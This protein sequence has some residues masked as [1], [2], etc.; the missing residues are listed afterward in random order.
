MIQT[1]RL[2]LALLP[3]DVVREALEVQARTLKI[4]LQPGGHPTPKHK[5]HLTLMFLGDA[6]PPDV[7]LKMRHAMRRISVAPFEFTLDQAGSFSGTDAWWIGSRQSS[8]ELLAL[9]ESIRELID[10]FVVAKD[11]KRFSPHV[12]IFRGVGAKLPSTSLPPFRW[13]VSEVALVRSHQ[14]EK[15]ARYEIVEKWALGNIH[16]QEGQLPLI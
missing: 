9:R 12:T 6:I 11:R 14:F 10:E 7:E 15:P 3:N 13:P 1:N 8:P 2:F 5:L 16:K 4:R